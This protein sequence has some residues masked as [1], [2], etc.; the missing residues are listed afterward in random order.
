MDVTGVP[1]H[2]SARLDASLEIQVVRNP[3]L[4]DI[5]MGFI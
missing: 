2:L 5:P 4:L 3:F 1:A